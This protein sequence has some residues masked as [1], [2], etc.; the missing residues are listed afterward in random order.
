MD[1]SAIPG[2]ILI[3]GFLY[4]CVA[5]RARGIF[6]VWIITAFTLLGFVFGLLAGICL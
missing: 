4:V 2:Y 6:E 1:A 3:T 5:L